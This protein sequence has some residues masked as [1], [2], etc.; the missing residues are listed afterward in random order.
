MSGLKYIFIG[1]PPPPFFT[2]TS[3]T[4]PDQELASMDDEQVKTIMTLLGVTEFF[5]DAPKDANLPL[6]AADVRGYLHKSHPTH[7]LFFIRWENAPI[8]AD[9][10]FALHGFRKSKYSREQYRDEVLL[11]MRFMN[12]PDSGAWRYEER[13]DDDGNRS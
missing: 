9:N 1:Q 11:L 13:E 8:P 7:W 10:G 5:T 2:G 6:G 3:L 12:R 4:F